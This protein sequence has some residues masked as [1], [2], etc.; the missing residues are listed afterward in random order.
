[1]PYWNLFGLA[2]FS[3]FHQKRVRRLFKKYLESFNYF[4]K[5]RF[6]CSGKLS[7]KKKTWKILQYLA[8]FETFGHAIF[9]RCRQKCVIM[10]SF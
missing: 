5:K 7:I 3:H 2:I 1:M 4:F 9:F 10:Q 8:L 6:W